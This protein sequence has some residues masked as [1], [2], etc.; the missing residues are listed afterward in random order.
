MQEEVENKSVMLI[1]NSTKFTGRVLKSAISKYLA[2]RSA[3]RRE[4]KMDRK[5]EKRAEQAKRVA[6]KEAKKE[7][8]RNVIPRGKQSVKDLIAQNQGVSSIDVSDKDMKGFEKI[9]RKYNVDFAVRKT[10]GSPPKYLVF[11]KA[12]DS[13]ALIGAMTEFT[14]K[15]EYK[16]DHPSIVKRLARGMVKGFQKIPERIRNKRQEH[17]R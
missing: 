15:K 4:K 17:D 9:A 1:I 11:F 2:H 8:K 10:K 13:D 7:A 12:K 3:K 14:R 5:T 6:E 16:R